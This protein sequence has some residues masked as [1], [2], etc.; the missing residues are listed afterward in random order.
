MPQTSRHAT[1][2]NV[3]KAI[4]ACTIRSINLALSVSAAFIPLASDGTESRHER[5]EKISDAI[6]QGLTPQ[7]RGFG[8]MRSIGEIERSIHQA[9]ARGTI[10]ARV[11]SALGNC[12]RLLEKRAL[13]RSKNAGRVA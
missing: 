3:L 4:P 12:L 6:D 7:K 2:L 1:D 13:L 10:R 8:P 5:R 9:K 11:R